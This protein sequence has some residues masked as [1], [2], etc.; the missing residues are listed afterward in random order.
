MFLKLSP[1]ICRSLGS[2]LRLLGKSHLKQGR[3]EKNQVERERGDSDDDSMWYPGVI[4]AHN[5]HH[6]PDVSDSQAPF[7][8]PLWHKRKM[9]LKRSHE[10]QKYA[11]K[12]ESPGGGSSVR[13]AAISG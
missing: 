2:S 8:D 12:S 10:L 6:Y 13:P 5:I 4:F 9:V 11:S 3:G 7:C 1:S